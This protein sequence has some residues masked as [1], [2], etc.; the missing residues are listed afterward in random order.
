[1][2]AIMIQIADLLALADEYQRIDPVEDKTLSN[3]V[4]ADSKKLTALRTTGDI[5]TARFNAAV[6]WFSDNWPDGAVWPKGIVRPK[7]AA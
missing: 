4:F 7:V 3:R 6:Q 1:M 5:T 2:L